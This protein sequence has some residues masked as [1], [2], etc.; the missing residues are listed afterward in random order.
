MGV[1]PVCERV[2]EP[3]VDELASVL[4]DVY[5]EFDFECI[6]LEVWTADEEGVWPPRLILVPARYRNTAL[7]LMDEDRTVLDVYITEIHGWDDIAYCVLGAIAHEI[8]VAIEDIKKIV[9]RVYQKG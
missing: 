6:E 7:A 2:V 9:V 5:A 8:E 4:R 3:K 1:N